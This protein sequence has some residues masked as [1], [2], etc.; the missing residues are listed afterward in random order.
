MSPEYYFYLPLIVDRWRKFGWEPVIFCEGGVNESWLLMK[1]MPQMKGIQWESLPTDTKHP[2][3]MIAQVS[4][5]Y[6]ACVT[7]S[8]DVLMTSDSDMLPLSDY[9]QFEKGTDKPIKTFGWDLTEFQQVPMCYICMPAITW[10]HVMD[11]TNNNYDALIEIE[12]FYSDHANSANKEV[13]WTADQQIITDR[14]QKLRE[15]V[16]NVERGVYPNG[17]AY[18]RVDRSAWNLNHEVF[19]D[20]HLERSLWGDWKKCH[21]LIDLLKKVWPEENF[22]WFFEY[23]AKFA[24]I[25]LL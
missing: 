1:D 11:L 24:E 19:I 18:G 15:S 8:G 3:E 16:H 13:R 17:Y 9:W 6:G 22:Q 14:L 10:R 2:M 23:T 7:N 12:L 5:L 4:R 20:A 25:E 21:R